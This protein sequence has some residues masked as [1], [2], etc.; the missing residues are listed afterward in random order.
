LTGLTSSS[1]SRLLRESSTSSS[2][3]RTRSIVSVIVITFRCWFPVVVFPVGLQGL[4]NRQQFAV[5]VGLYDVIVGTPT[6][7]EVHVF[8]VF[9]SGQDHRRQLPESRV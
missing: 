8:V 4:Y 2:V 1:M 9:G 6:L 5:A 7:A 3:S